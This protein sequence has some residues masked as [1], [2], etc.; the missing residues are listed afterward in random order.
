MI[1]IGYQERCVLFFND[2]FVPVLFYHYPCNRYY[3]KRH[4]KRALVMLK[5]IEVLELCKKVALDYEGWEFTVGAFKDKRQKHT[6]KMVRPLWTFSPGSALAQPIAG[7]A[8]KQV[9]K[10]YKQLVTSSNWTHRLSHKNFHKDYIGGYRIY[11]LIEDDA[12]NRIHRMFNE[13]IKL[14]DNTYDFSSEQALLKSIPFEIEQVG[15]VKNCIIQGCLGNY[16]FIKQY[17]NEDIETEYPK[18]LIDVKK[19]MEYFN[20]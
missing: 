7:V 11:D 12:E 18:D 14:I 2:K 17:Y 19:V 16:D 6:V 10:I 13:G 20:I 8:N 3:I 5:K 4:N 15:G 1:Y 9:D